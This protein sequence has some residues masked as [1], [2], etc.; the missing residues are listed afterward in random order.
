M[1]RSRAG[2]IGFNRVSTTTAA[3]GIWTVSEAEAL[4]RAGEWPRGPLAPTSLTATAGN[5]QLTLSWTAPATTHGTITNY[6]VEYTPS[7]GSAVTVLTGSTST[8]Y[9]L[10]GLTNGTSY[11]VRVAA[12]NF[13]AGDWSGTA[14][15]TPSTMA[16]VTGGTVTTPGDGYRYHTF[17]TSSTLDISGSSLTA[18]VLV[19]GG[20]GGGSNSGG[21]GGG[22]LYQTAHT[23]NA[24]SYVVTV[25]DS[26]SPGVNGG[27]S[28]IGSLFT[29]TGGNRGVNNWG[30]GGT[31]G[32]P[33][34][35]S[36]TTG[37]A[38]GAGDTVRGC[39]YTGGGG[40]GAGG[41]GSTPPCDVR[42][43][44]GGA[45]ITVWG[46]TYGQG[47]GGVDQDGGTNAPANIG[48]GGSG[49]LSRG[50]SGIVIIRY[51]VV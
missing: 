5:T 8:S 38:G 24:G 10:T 43:V 14:T 23:L 32:F 3:S 27:S 9:T 40:G 41:V 34:S 2:Y 48:R 20:G 19:V 17:T 28:S 16:T 11:S 30:N 39:D 45:G 49:Y 29:A 44:G 42:F 36:N 51:L 13:T 46:T 6:L 1:S 15:G 35:T 33:T 22:V 18:D 7:G 50:G 37:N 47:G 31:S 21:G 25:A 4:R 12:V 26:V